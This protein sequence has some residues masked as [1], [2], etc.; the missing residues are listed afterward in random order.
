MFEVYI[1]T[2]TSSKNSHI[3]FSEKVYFCKN[4]CKVSCFSDRIDA[5]IELGKIIKGRENSKYAALIEEAVYIQ[6]LKNHWF[7]IPFI[8][9]ALDAI[10]LML[11]EKKLKLFSGKYEPI[12][13]ADFNRK[14]RIAVISPGNIPVAGFHD[15]FSVLVSGN[16]YQGKLSDQDD[17]LLPVLAEILSEIDSRFAERISF[18]SKINR[19]SKVIATGSNNSSR[20]FHYYFGQ[21]PHILRKNRNSIAI[22]SGS[23]TDD[24]LENLF[25]DIFLYFGLGCRSVSHLFVP[26]GYT[27][28]RLF[29]V[30]E[31]LGKEFTM[32]H[33]YLNNLDYQK[34]VHLM[35]RLPFLDSGI[36]LLI[37]NKTLPSPIGI[38][39]YQFYSSKNEFNEYLTMEKENLQ[40]VGTAMS[41]FEKAIPFGRAQQPDIDDFADGI[42][43]IK[44]LLSKDGVR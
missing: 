40:C 30:F 1:I 10:A 22:L 13:D 23:E 19:F 8:Y 24:D 3:F 29:S 11:D 31:K 15:F 28:D 21:Y 42:D 38:I 6:S 7:T 27:F 14:E 44:W 25:Q 43:V 16:D 26:A 12:A 20:Y 35:N 17:Q 32:H 36:A 33:H 2:E 18:V 4:M 34:T 37:E 39:N 41:E 5:F 9:Y